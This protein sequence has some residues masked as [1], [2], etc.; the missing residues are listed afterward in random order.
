MVET[1]KDAPELGSFRLVNITLHG[2]A[3]LEESLGVGLMGVYLKL[4]RLV[5]VAAWILGPR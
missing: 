3:D 4:S 1:S 2:S 5:V